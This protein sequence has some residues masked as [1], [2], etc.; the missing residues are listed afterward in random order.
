MK[1]DTFLRYDSV[2][3]ANSFV[4]H[5]NLTNHYHQR[6]AIFIIFS[7]F[8][9]NHAMIFLLITKRKYILTCLVVIALKISFQNLIHL[10]TKNSRHVG[11][12]RE[13]VIELLW[14]HIA[15]TNWRK[16]L[17]AWRFRYFVLFRLN[18]RLDQITNNKAGIIREQ[19]ILTLT[20]KMNAAKFVLIVFSVGIFFSNSV[21]V[22]NSIVNNL[23][24][25]I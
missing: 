6:D 21:W 20:F 25:S 15:S 16:M 22:L 23:S 11:E 12:S 24:T 2:L 9:S 5:T 8:I 4:N 7:V 19:F 3:P 18:Q 13:T 17:S 10:K 14:W 1:L